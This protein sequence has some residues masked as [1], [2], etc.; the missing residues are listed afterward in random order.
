MGV[1]RARRLAAIAIALLAIV[2]LSAP[3]LASKPERIDINDSVDDVVCDIPVHVTVTGFSLLHIQ[4][5]VIPSTGPDSDDFWIGVIQDH[6]DVTFTNA[7]GV[8]LTNAVRQTRQ[9]DAF[10]DNG[11]GTWTYT[12]SINGIPEWLRTVDGQVLKD[13]GR[14]SFSDVLYLG[15]LST[16][17]DDAFV[18]STITGITGPHPDAESDF[19]LFCQAFTQ[20]LG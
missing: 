17:A 18:S 19:A 6:V 2:V 16:D 3:A 4:D 8:T 14:I 12:Y 9:E 1:P 5:V 13:V 10:V 7:D 20:V 11:D 15:D